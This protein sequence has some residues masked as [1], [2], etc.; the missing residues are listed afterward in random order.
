MIK[1]HRILKSDLSKVNA[2]N[3]HAAGMSN[4]SGMTISHFAYAP[5]QTE[6]TIPYTIEIMQEHVPIISDIDFC[7]VVRTK[8]D[9]TATGPDGKTKEDIGNDIGEYDYADRVPSRPLD[10]PPGFQELYKG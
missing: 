4:T 7:V 8:V 10:L 5:K 6:A 2:L 3:V 9:L 1:I